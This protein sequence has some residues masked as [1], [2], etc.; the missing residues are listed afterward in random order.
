MLLAFV[1]LITYKLDPSLIPRLLNP[2]V[3]IFLHIFNASGYSLHL[4]VYISVPF[5]PP[6]L[7]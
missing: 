1:F 6:A 7:K 4:Y 2:N 5:P 3:E